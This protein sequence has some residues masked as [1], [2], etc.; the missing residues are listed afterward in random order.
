MFMAMVRVLFKA[1]P[2]VAARFGSWLVQ[3]DEYFRVSQ[4]AS[5]SI[6]NSLSTVHNSNGLLTDKFHRTQRVRLELGVGLLET[7]TI[8]NSGSRTLGC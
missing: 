5:S 4:G 1:Y 6:A 2:T 8:V 3:V 7:R